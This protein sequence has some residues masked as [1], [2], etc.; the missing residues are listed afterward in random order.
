MTVASAVKIECLSYDGVDDY[1]D[2]AVGLI[3]TYPAT[4][5]VTYRGRVSNG[6]VIFSCE[7]ADTKYLYVGVDSLSISRA[8]I[9]NT[10]QYDLS[11]PA[12]SDKTNTT[13]HGVYISAISR[14]ITVNKSILATGVDNASMIAVARLH[15]SRL[16]QSDTLGLIN[17]NI[18]CGGIY[19]RS[20]TQAECDYN[21]DHPHNPLRSGLIGLWGG[22]ISGGSLI[23][24]SIN[25]NNGVITGATTVQQ[26]KLAGRVNSA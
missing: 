3:S 11:G 6:A 1:T 4:I 20:L 25:S 15:F 8:V 19:N 16:R 7:E 12:V 2:I 21:V 22:K 24:E 14:K 18:I 5:F 10:T 26:N 23:D 17:G 13:M 9:R